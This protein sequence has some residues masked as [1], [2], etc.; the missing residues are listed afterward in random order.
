[1][2]I[3]DTN[4]RSIA[5]TFDNVDAVAKKIESPGSIPRTGDIVT[6]ISSVHQVKANVKVIQMKDRIIGHLLNIKA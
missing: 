2:K 5:R 6:L 3:A 1:M 4:I